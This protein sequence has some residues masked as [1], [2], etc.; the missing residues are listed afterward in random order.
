MDGLR[1]CLPGHLDDPA[2]VQVGL[3]GRCPTDVPSFIRQLHMERVAVQFRVDGD[4][5]DAEFTGGPDHPD[6]DLAAVGHQ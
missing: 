3:G 1:T 4:R 2:G 6:R 5:A